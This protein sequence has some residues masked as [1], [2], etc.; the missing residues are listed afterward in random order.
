MTTKEEAISHLEDS[1]YFVNR[2]VEALNLQMRRLENY[3]FNNN[4][5]ALWSYFSDA[6]FY[7]VALKRLR[8]AILTAKSISFVWDNMKSYFDQFDLEIKD[9]IE[10]RHA[11]E[12]IDDHIKNKGRT[13]IKNSKMYTIICTENGFVWAGK[14][15]DPD[16]FHR[17]AEILVCKYR[18]LSSNVFREYR[19]N[20]TVP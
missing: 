13:G 3:D 1:Q 5:D 18:E 6:H 12:H 7:I 16:K 15:F 8:Q 10:M 19:E 4:P 17:S 14:K 9:A 11:I 20:N 2:A